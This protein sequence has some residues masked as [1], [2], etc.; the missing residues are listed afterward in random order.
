[1]ALRLRQRDPGL[2]KARPG[3]SMIWRGPGPFSPRP[4]CASLTRRLWRRPGRSEVV[5]ASPFRR[6]AEPAP[7]LR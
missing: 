6:M 3:V 5:A 7:P 4:S 2:A 1:L